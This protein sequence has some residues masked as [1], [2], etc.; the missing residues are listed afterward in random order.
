MEFEICHA[1]LSFSMMY[2]KQI[3]LCAVGASIGHDGAPEYAEIQCKYT[4]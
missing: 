2:I 4:M 3:N 1:V